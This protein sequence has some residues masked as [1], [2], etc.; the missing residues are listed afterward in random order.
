M[1]TR[2]DDLAQIEADMDAERK[3]RS[4][5]IP[6]PTLPTDAPPLDPRAAALQQIEADLAASRR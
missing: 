2:A 3:R 5:G 4:G 6:T 1:T